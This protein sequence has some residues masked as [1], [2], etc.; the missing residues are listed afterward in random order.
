MSEN[1]M[2]LQKFVDLKH[3]QLKAFQFKWLSEN[4]K[5]PKKWPLEAEIEYWDEQFLHFVMPEL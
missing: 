1:K 3:K 4:G 5:N 2:S